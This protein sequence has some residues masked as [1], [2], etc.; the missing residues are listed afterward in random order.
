MV[1]CVTDCERGAHGKLDAPV[2]QGNRRGSKRHRQRH[3]RR[4]R[5]GREITL[6]FLAYSGIAVIV[7]AIVGVIGS[8]VL[9]F[10]MSVISLRRIPR[11][12]LTDINKF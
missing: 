3:A 2:P 11:F 9:A 5:C 7:G 12:E 8:V 6:S 1:N 4:A 10:V